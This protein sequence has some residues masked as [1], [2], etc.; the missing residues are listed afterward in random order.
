VFLI[1]TLYFICTTLSAGN[2][3]T[4]SGVLVQFLVPVIVLQPAKC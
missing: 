1:D 3:T 4:A 2:C